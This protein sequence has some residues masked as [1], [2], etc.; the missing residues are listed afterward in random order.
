MTALQ[1]QA[2]QMMNGLSDEHLRRVIDFIQSLTL[3][4]EAEPEMTEK[5]K[6]FYQLTSTHLE[7]PEDF[8][9]DK[10]RMEALREK[11]GPFN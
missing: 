3:P 2:A 5:R 1:A 4:H 9:P 11:Y 8:D 10:E 6:A 7:F